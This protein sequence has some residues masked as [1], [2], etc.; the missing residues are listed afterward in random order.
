MKAVILAAGKGTRMRPLTE[1]EAKPMLKVAGRPILEHNIDQIRDRVDEIIIVAGY[2]IEDFREYFSS[3]KIT[4]VEQEEALGTADAALQAKEKIDDSA[5]IM[6]GDDIYPGLP[7]LSAHSSCLLGMDVD[8]PSKFGIYQI[9]DGRVKD[10]EEKPENPSSTMANIG[11]YLVGSEFFDLLDDVEMSE[12]GEYEI[13]DAVKEYVGSEQVDF[14]E[15]RRWLPCSYP[16]QLMDANLELLEE[17]E[18]AIDGDMKNSETGGTV[19]IEEDARVENSEL[20]NVVIHSGATVRGCNLENVVVRE[21]S[22]LQD[23]ETSRSYYMPEYPDAEKV[24]NV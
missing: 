23:V 8:E 14:Q 4:I 22:T 19:I 17:I 6:N 3:D 10:I 20:T 21:D 24:E 11:L 1:E 16:D 2:R 15:A 7:D 12:R 9:E 13:T 18:T 5:L